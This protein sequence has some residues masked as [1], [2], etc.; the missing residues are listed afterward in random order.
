MR[1]ERIERHFG[2]KLAAGVGC[3][4][5]ILISVDSNGEGVLAS[6]ASSIYAHGVALTSGSGTKTP[7]I[8][9]YVNL[10]RNAQITDLGNITVTAGGTIYLGDNGL[11]ADAAPGTIDQ[12]IGIALNDSTVF[13]DLDMQQLP[14]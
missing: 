10:Y 3:G 6:D 1:I 4:A 8:S 5:G 12:K 14:A 7:G 11:V 13:I 9:Q 2:V